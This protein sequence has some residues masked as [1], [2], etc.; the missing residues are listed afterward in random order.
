MLRIFLR[1]SAWPID[2]WKRRRK[3]CSSISWLFALS[4]CSSM[5]R[6]ACFFAIVLFHVFA[7][8]ELG[9]H[10]KLMS[11]EAHRGLGDLT[12]HAF[13]FEQNLARPDHRHP[14]LWRALTLTHTGLGGLL[15]DRL[16][17]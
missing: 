4:S 12:R 16:I 13:H 3:S 14:L 10:G 8:D 1:P 5:S 17:G 9:L 7:R 15:R 6:N 11:G 2:I